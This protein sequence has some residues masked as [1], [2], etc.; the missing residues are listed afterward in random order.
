MTTPSGKIIP[1]RQR[2]IALLGSRSV[3]KS[4]LTV[5][6][7]D[8][9][10]VDSYYPTI[11]NTFQKVVKY[12]GQD[13]N[14]DIIDTAGQDEFSILSS[15]HAVGLHGW[16]LVYSVS[17]RSSFEMIQIVRE[18]VLNYTGRE[19]VPMVLVGNKSDL[20]VQRQV[21]R[22]EGA[23]LAASWGMCGFTEASARHNENV[24]KIFELVVAQIEK[25]MNPEPEEPAKSG[26][27]VM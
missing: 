10:F 24:S 12:K 14:L 19:N 8:S 3:G 4:S 17:S 13:F 20:A 5:Q 16:V 6:F 27:R 21:P 9:H 2:K 25:D 11:E 15:K 1:P 22:E 23:A 26:C 7:V 18:K